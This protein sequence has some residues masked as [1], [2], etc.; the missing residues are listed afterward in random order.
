MITRVRRFLRA[1][2]APIYETR[3]KIR[4]AVAAQRNR[5]FLASEVARF[6]A[7][8]GHSPSARVLVAIPTY[9][10]PGGVID[11]VHSALEQSLSDVAVIVV[12]DG[13]GLPDS[14]P[15]DPR[16]TAVSLSRNTAVAGLA[17]NVAIDLSN[18]EYLAYLDDD[19]TWTAD[20]LEIAVAA[21]DANPRI[22]AVY[23]TVHRRRS[24]GV[25]IDVLS[26]PFDRA[27][28]RETPYIDTNSIVARRST[29][30]RFSM[31]PRTKDTLPKEDWDYM[32]R[33][34]RRHEVVHV[35]RA[36]VLYTVNQDSYYTIWNGWGD[37]ASE[38]ASQRIDPTDE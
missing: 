13:G 6:R 37:T 34:S 5:S 18:S 27:K 22:G 38:T 21:L 31:V 24:D 32:W 36:T 19:N 9:K 20:H 28:M 33:L 35:P 26:A 1:H 12:D 10:R 30:P 25:V 16:L 14:L 2:R 11:A 17:R 3:N 4:G 29:S 23:T 8:I 7:E 15:D